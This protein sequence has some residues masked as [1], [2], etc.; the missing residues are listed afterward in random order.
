MNAE[1]IEQYAAKVD[2]S[3]QPEWQKFLRHFE[4]GEGFA[5]II[6]LV[7]NR[8]IAESCRSQFEIWL[9]AHNAASLFALSL[10]TPESI[11][12][13]PEK[14]MSI[15]P[16]IG[17]IWADG[18]G[19]RT[20]YEDAWNRCAVK[21]NRTRDV[22]AA[23]FAAPIIL[24]GAPWIRETLRD[25]APDFWS[26]RAFIAEI[27]PSQ[28]ERNAAHILLE[29]PANTEPSESI[30]DPDLTL[31]A[32]ADL[33]GKPGQERQLGV[34][35]DRAGTELMNRGRSVE[36]LSLLQEAM[37][38]DEAAVKQEPGRADYQ[39]DLSV[40][41]DRLGDLQRALGEGEAARQYYE[42]S[43]LLRDQLV[44]QEPGRA[45]YLND[46]AVSYERMGD[47]YNSLK[48]SND[49]RNYFEKA[50]R[51]RERLVAQEPTRADYLRA[52]VV[53]LSR[54]GGTANLQRA[55]KIALDLQKTNRLNKSDEPMLTALQQMLEQAKSAGT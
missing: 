26:V 49:S 19:D 5:F 37:E 18:T 47:V 46:L 29:R 34:L 16:P 54:I 48:Q 27:S 28:L 42:K 51:E 2:L 50:L 20:I 12:N 40:S 43:L 14:L 8:A 38:I 53:P 10:R 33:R 22:I 13:L 36:A 32:I 11:S 41:Y 30:F 23:R 25:D 55:L 4:L 15:A 7:P 35:L 44:K 1:P 3:A 6:L 17:P 52:I 9:Q 31:R 45:D 39:R 24:V 21:L